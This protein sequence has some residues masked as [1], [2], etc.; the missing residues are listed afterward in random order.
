MR[1]PLLKRK[2]ENTSIVQS[3]MNTF[4]LT[5]MQRETLF[6]F[7]LKIPVPFLEGQVCPFHNNRFT[8]AV[9]YRTFNAYLPGLSMLSR[10]AIYEDFRGSSAASLPG[11]ITTTPVYELER[12]VL[13]QLGH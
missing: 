12:F 3:V 13:L 7:K 9:I 10:D 1:P 8:T 4:M 11:K 6:M 5:S 2:G